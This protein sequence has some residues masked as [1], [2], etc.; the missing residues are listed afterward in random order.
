M[1]NGQT[2]AFDIPIDQRVIV[3]EDIDCLESVVSSRQQQQQDI[4]KDME[5]LDVPA[6]GCAIAEPSRIIVDSEETLTLS[7]LLNILDGVLEQPGRV[8]IMTTNHPEKLDPALI[9]PGRI[10]AIV[11]FENCRRHEVVELV[12]G[13]AEYVIPAARVRHLADEK[14]T[15]AEVTR[16]IFEHMHDTEAMMLALSDPVIPFVAANTPATNDTRGCG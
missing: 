4:P 9:R 7:H 1:S 11:K 3:I 6:W 14:F 8:L 13:L 5:A 2:V 16:T 10:D 12:A 15:P